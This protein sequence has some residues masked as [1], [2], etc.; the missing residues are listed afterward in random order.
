[1]KHSFYAFAAAIVMLLPSC[2]LDEDISV[3][4]PEKYTLTVNVGAP[5]TKVVGQV[6]SDM[7]LK[8]FHKL[9]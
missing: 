7:M 4:E 8:N 1:M 3:S 2:T 9:R 5:A 6:A